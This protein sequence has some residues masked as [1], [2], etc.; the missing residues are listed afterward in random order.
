MGRRGPDREQGREREGCEVAEQGVHVRG[1]TPFEHAGTRGVGT[2][3]RPKGWRGDD[4][5]CPGVRSTPGA[6]LRPIPRGR[7]AFLRPTPGGGR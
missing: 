3:S 7:G 6:A 4:G 1:G 2:V 5:A